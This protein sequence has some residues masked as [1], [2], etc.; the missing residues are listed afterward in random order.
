MS[1]LR[2]RTIWAIPN[3]KNVY[4]PNNELKYVDTFFASLRISKNAR[5]VWIFRPKYRIGCSRYT[6]LLLYELLTPLIIIDPYNLNYFQRSVYNEIFPLIL[7]FRAF[8]SWQFRH[9]LIDFNKQS[10]V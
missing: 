5:F 1:D 7:I 6:V 4:G 2:I 8:D 10:V 9:I 3:Q